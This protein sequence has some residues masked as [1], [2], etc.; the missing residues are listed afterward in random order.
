MI[1]D[2]PIADSVIAESVAGLSAGSGSVIPYG[3]PR[4]HTYIGG[5]A[6]RGTKEQIEALLREMAQ[7]HAEEDE[8][9]AEDA[10]P[11]KKRAIRVLGPGKAQVTAGKAAQPLYIPPKL[12]A[13]AGITAAEAEAVYRQA[14]AMY[15]HREAI[16]QDDEDLESVVQHVRQRRQVAVQTLM[17]QLDA[18]RKISQ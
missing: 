12:Q 11:A 8:E 14:Y 13:E 2:C 1:A 18:L 7:Q 9:A 5:K 3:A 6:V 17:Q 15:M 16:R 10:Q 4:Y